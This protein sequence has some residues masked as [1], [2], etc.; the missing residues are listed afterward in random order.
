MFFESVDLLYYSL[1]KTTLKRAGSSYAESYEWIKNKRATTNPKNEH[2]NNCFHYSSIVSLNHWNIENHPEELSKLQP[3]INKYNWRDID[4]PSDPKDWK[5]FEQNNETIA[6]AILYAPYKTK[7]IIK[8]A[9]KSKHD[10][11]REN[12]VVLLMIS[13]GKRSDRVKKYYYLALKNKPTIDG[14]NRPIRS[15][16]R[17]LRGISSN[18]VGDH[19]CLNCFHSKSTDNALKKH[20]RLCGN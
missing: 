19:Y 10:R 3:F 1:H 7:Q 18:H 9:C 15:L 8:I 2:D 16:S 4:F 14:Y 13:D 5:K 11:K 17:L 12:Q 20:E 6:L